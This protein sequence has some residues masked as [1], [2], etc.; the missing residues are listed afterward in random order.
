MTSI[1]H[2]SI[3]LVDL[4][5]HITLRYDGDT[6]D[7]PKVG[8]S[9][10]YDTV[11]LDANGSKVGTVTGAGKVGY[12]R[13]TDEHVMLHYREEITLPD[14][15]IVTEGWIDGNAIQAGQWQTL[16]AVGASGRYVGWTGVRR[17][18]QEVAHKVFR[19]SIFLHS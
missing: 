17:L 8:E 2:E 7:A 5:E 4:A 16:D 18:R 1:S 13:P 19:A 10:T 6:P 15:T 11:L 12:K 9:D 14:G 3:A